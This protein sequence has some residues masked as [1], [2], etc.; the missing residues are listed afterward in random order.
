MA[1]WWQTPQEVQDALER[2]FSR[3]E[4]TAPSGSPL[5]ELII[6]ALRSL[7]DFLRD[8]LPSFRLGEG[9]GL[10]LFVLV[11]GGFGLL[12]GHLLLRVIARTG[13]RRKDDEG[14]VEGR[15]QLAATAA[16]AADWDAMASSLAAE[17]HWREAAFALYHALLSRL[18]ARGAVRLDPSKT[19]GDY[20][21]ESRRDPQAGHLLERFLRGFE[22]VAFG[23]R[24]ADESD[25]G[26]LRDLVTAPPEH[27]VDHG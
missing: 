21:R 26:R 20:R 7:L 27:A 8:L 12:A 11:A 4:L 9:E 25:F 15:S 2:A 13:A 18:A 1:V 5:R 24:S 3:P 17:G 10:A 16:S 23:A 14:R 6:R 22:P 19:P